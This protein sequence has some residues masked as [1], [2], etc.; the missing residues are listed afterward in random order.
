MVTN[1]TEVTKMNR[2]NLVHILFTILFGCTID[3][4]IFDFIQCIYE[5]KKSPNTSNVEGKEV[6]PINLH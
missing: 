3:F 2:L 5:Q 6:Q 4:A 1:V